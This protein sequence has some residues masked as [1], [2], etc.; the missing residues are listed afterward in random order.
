[1]KK[2]V[3]V[4][5]SGNAYQLEEDGFET[6]TEYLD[7]ARL[8]LKGNPDLEEIMSDL[9]QSVAD[10]IDR[11]LGPK[12][13]VVST[14]EVEQIVEEM[15]PVDSS[16]D[17]DVG[18]GE[19][20]S[21][22]SASKEGPDDEAAE[23]KLY[24]LTSDREKMLTGVCA[25]LA[26]YFGM[27]VSIVRIIFVALTF[28]TSGFVI[29][30]YLGLALILPEAKTPQQHAAAYGAPFD[31]RDV[32]DRAKSK[33]ND[34]RNGKE[35]RSQRRYWNRH[36]R[37]AGFDGLGSVLGLVVVGLGILIGLFVLSRILFWLGNPFFGI[38][39]YYPGVPWWATVLMVIIGVYVIGWIFGDGKYENRSVL[40]SAFIKTSKVLLILLVIYLGFQ[41]LTAQRVGPGLAILA[42]S[43]L[44]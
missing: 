14:E 34:M 25:G 43:P 20:A 36:A 11:F 4:N 5:L 41:L 3:N 7:S 38:S 35:W 24:K 27:D 42:F 44:S 29:L 8:R 37:N 31:A 19:G 16:I 22:S 32:I 18:A 28:A 2:V 12:K 39:P 10:K 40:G 17:D 23:R 26:A 13:N 9:E 1:M 30:V 21:R 6:L 33:F 15:G